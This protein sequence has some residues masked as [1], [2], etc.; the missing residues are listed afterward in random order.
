MQKAVKS[1]ACYPVR[2]TI[3]PIIFTAV[4]MVSL[5]G[6]GS[7]R[8]SPHKAIEPPVNIDINST[9]TEEPE[10]AGGMPVLPQPPT[11]PPRQ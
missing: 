9:E 8:L 7:N 11:L 2:L 6:C 3:K 10:I 1:S 4:A 5:S